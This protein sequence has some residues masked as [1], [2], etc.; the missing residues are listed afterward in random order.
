MSLNSAEVSLILQELNLQGAFIRQIVQP[1]FDSIAF[2]VFNNDDAKTL[3][4]C[5][6]PGAC[7]IH[8]TRQGIP[9]NEKP[10]RFMQFL[11]AH[12]KGC[13]IASC[14]QIGQERVIKLKLTQA[15]T[16]LFMF[17][18]LWSGAANII[19][20][21]ENLKILDVFFRRPKRNEITGG[22]FLPPEPRENTTEQPSKFTTIRTF[23]DSNDSF[24]LKVD[25]WYAEHAESLSKE[26]LL[27]QAEKRYTS[28]HSRM[29]VALAHL[30][31][32]KENFLHAE[33]LKHQGDLILSYGHLINTESTFLEC[34]DYDTNATIRIP[35]D[36]KKNVHDNAAEYYEK[37]KKALSG[38]KELEYDISRLKKEILDLD[39][40]YTAIRNE[41]NPLRIEQMLRKQTTPKQQIK[42]TIP[43]IQYSIDG[44]TI[45]VGRTASENDE[46]LRHHAK[47]HDMW[48][49]SRDTAG[50]FVFIKNRPGKTVPL[51]I[52][53]DAGN[54]AVYF[55]KARKAGTAD[56]YYTHV[57]YL[58]RAKN[59]PRGTVLPTH[60]KNI[61]IKL[62]DERLKR[63]KI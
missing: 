11:R 22:I 52:L 34:T 57:K 40:I 25:R 8:E 29:E 30:E 28:Q 16:V 15:D 13:R 44:W 7:R 61:T 56:L 51:N 1:G 3:L 32:K 23:D 45:L 9:R 58:R 27:E 10:L 38:L 49:H 48:L 4:V 19:V 62:D 37:Y 20:T 42:K 47:G 36:S 12:V 2:N 53:L 54:L 43:G 17:I 39:A 60:E 24:N 26:A 31:K 59:A 41:E 14:E 50:G 33:Q 63:L 5:L 35:I 18:R 55:S 46:L 6:A 21:D